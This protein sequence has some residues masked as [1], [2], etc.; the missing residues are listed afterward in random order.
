MARRSLAPKTTLLAPEID[1][2]PTEERRHHAT[3]ERVARPISD[4]AGRS[5]RPY[6]AIDT[7]VAMERRGTITASMR[8]AAEDFRARFAAA[9]L[10]PLHA[11]DYSR[12]RDGERGRGNSAAP[13]ALRA[14]SAREDVWRAIVALGGPGSPGGS[15]VWHVVGWERSIKEWAVEQG[16]NG[17][18]ISQEAASGILV[19]ALGALEAHYRCV[20]VL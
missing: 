4:E 3:I 9:Q 15:C 1:L 19:A 6:R 18:R 8:Q 2:G 16:W 13:A 11:L 20:R 17:R 7:L 5:A 14:E 12:L 10:D